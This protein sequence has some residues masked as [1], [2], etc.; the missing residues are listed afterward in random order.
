MKTDF[1]NYI[2]SIK[3]FQL[4]KNDLSYLVIFFFK[5][6]NL[7]KYNYN[8]YNKNYWLLFLILNNGNLSL[9]IQNTNISNY[10][11]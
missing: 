2:N 8:T 4:G 5:N 3:F 11:L 1:S 6:L 10:I 9:K 7:I